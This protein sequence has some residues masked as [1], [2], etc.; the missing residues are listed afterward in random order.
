[1]KKVIFIL[2]TSTLLTLS[3]NDDSKKGR[4]IRYDDLKTELGLNEEQNTKF[5]EV[6]AKY[7]KINE[8]S[9]AVAKAEGAKF[10]RV[11]AFKKMEERNKQQ[12]NEMSVFLSPEQ[13]TLY[14]DFM[15]KN[16]RKRPRY[17]DELLTTIKTELALTEE[18]SNI[19][20]AANNAFEKSYHN[21]HDIY[22]GNSELAQEYWAKFDNERKS[23]LKS[24]FSEKQ[25]ALFL[26]LV[27]PYD[28]AKI[29]E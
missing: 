20:E 6:V 19:L 25:Y 9:R 26:E 7:K 23:A 13:M 21:A 4:D 11:E 1:M 12:A 2:I 16:S 18:Q 29:K 8:E 14:T 28:K 10:D 22:H 24:I 5:D 17:N 3:C 15:E 27:K